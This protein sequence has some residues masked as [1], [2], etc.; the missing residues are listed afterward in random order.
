MVLVGCAEQLYLD[1]RD[2]RLVDDQVLVW[3]NAS[4]VAD[5]K[6]LLAVAEELKELYSNTRARAKLWSS[7]TI[8]SLVMGG[9][10]LTGRL[11]GTA[12]H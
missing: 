4:T 3:H 7:G 2:R 12:L 10:T 5:E 1:E 8:R 11:A 6:L 9:V